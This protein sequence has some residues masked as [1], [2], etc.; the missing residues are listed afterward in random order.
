VEK[1]GPT[2]EKMD[3]TMKS[4]MLRAVIAA[5]QFVDWAQDEG[6]SWKSV[7]IGTPSRYVAENATVNLRHWEANG[8][9]Q[10]R[11]AGGQKK[12]ILNKALWQF[13]LQEMRRLWARGVCVS[14]WKT[15][16]LP[17]VDDEVKFAAENAR[18]IERL[19]RYHVFKPFVS[20]IW[21]VNR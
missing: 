6:G 9:Q 15:P 19:E 5:L 17:G 14:F 8:W 1:E 10:R 12:D 7:I 21:L 16:I 11:R 2:G 4:A 3:C 13:L 20:Q 18:K